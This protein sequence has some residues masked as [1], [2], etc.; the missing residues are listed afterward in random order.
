M[1]DNYGYGWGVWLIPDD[2]YLIEA[3]SHQ[4]HVTISCNMEKEFAYE[5][6]NT[7]KILYGTEHKVLFEPHCDLFIDNS[8]YSNNDV[9]KC[10]SGY[11]CSSPKWDLFRNIHKKYKISNPQLNNLGNFS[12]SPHLTYSYAQRIQDVKYANNGNLRELNCKLV[13]ADIR[14]KD[15]SK[16]CYVES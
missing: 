16:W 5:F 1:E 4:P 14:N 11:Q 3:L 13:I 15:P 2:R 12:K 8:S 7:L 9:Y 6:Y 10:C